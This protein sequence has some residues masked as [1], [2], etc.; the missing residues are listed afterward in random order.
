M[1]RRWNPAWLTPWLEHALVPVALVLFAAAAAALFGV[2]QFNP[3]Q[4]HMLAAQLIANG[5]V[6]VLS[7]LSRAGRLGPSAIAVPV[8]VNAPLA[9]LGGVDIYVAFCAIRESWPLVALAIPGVLSIWA[10]GW[11]SGNADDDVEGEGGEEPTDPDIESPR[12]FETIRI[13]A[14]LG[15]FYGVSWGLIIL[16]IAL[17][18]AWARLLKG[19]LFDH[20]DVSPAV[21]WDVLK[22]LGA[23]KFLA[24]L[25]IYPVF[26]LVF[27]LVLGLWAAVWEAWRRS[28]EP[29]AELTQADATFIDRTLH[30]TV[31]WLNA[32]RPRFA[33]A[34]IPGFM[35]LLFGCAFAAPVLVAIG[36]YWIVPSWVE[37]H[38]ALH[39]WHFI[40]TSI[41][42][43]I[44]ISLFAG[45]AAGTALGLYLAR[46]LPVYGVALAGYRLDAK[47]AK[48][49][50]TVE[51][52]RRAIARMVRRGEISPLRQPAPREIVELQNGEF[53][54]LIFWSAIG[55][56]AVTAFFAWRD[57]S[58]YALLT[59][60]G[61]E[62]ADYWT[63]QR[64][65]VPYAAVRSVTVTCVSTGDNHID[66]GY[67][68]DAGGKSISLAVDPREL[69]DRVAF[70]TH[71][72]SILRASGARFQHR[73]DG[74]CTHY[75]ETVAPGAAKLFYGEAL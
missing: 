54:G 17:F 56:L 7:A 38:R 64:H 14:Y 65:S 6:L 55:L 45:M 73:I 75:V 69:E 2:G 63:G 66:A 59:D 36:Q 49:A 43:S 28:R 48:R 42:P 31:D 29:V 61:V 3:P 53:R 37:A 11:L 62:Y 58:S 74:D 35:V 10:S 67:E 22:S 20:F 40:D 4:S 44:V 1:N 41:G 25:W 9:F 71:V 50:E 27:M 19:A 57:F 33:W 30:E 18:A 5:V 47:N 8:L 13:Y 26:I 32:H 12:P 24:R 60:N 39:G 52:Y 15:L 72:D 51:K 21:M 46:V 70:L 23:I 16:E 68:I 34:A